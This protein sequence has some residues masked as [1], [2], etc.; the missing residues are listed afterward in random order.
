MRIERESTQGLLRAARRLQCRDGEVRVPLSTAP[1]RPRDQQFV[2]ERDAR[3]RVHLLQEPRAPGGRV[4]ENAHLYARRR[5]RRRR[6]DACDD[7]KYTI[8]D[9]I[10]HIYTSTMRNNDHCNYV[11]FNTTYLGT[12]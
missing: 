9:Y 5:L 12:L 1:R 4:L 7:D 8:I 3:Q 11:I 6:G 10:A 2:L